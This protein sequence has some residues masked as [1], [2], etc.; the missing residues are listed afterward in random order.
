M[1]ASAYGHEGCVDLLISAGARPNVQSAVCYF[2]EIGFDM[3]CS[4]RA[5]GV[6][7]RREPLLCLGLLPLEMNPLFGSF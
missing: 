7:N 6:W 3:R 5:Y 2:Q 4:K 1:Y